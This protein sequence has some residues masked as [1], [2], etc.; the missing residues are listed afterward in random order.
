MKKISIVS[1]IIVVCTIVIGFEFLFVFGG[2]VLLLPNPAKP[3]IKSAE[4]NFT[5]RYEIDGETRILDDTLVCKF[6][7]FSIDEGR[8]KTRKWK[9][10][11]K[12]PQNNELFSYNF[13]NSKYYKP[14]YYEIVLQNIGQYKVL[15]ATASAEYFFQDPDYDA[16]PNMPCISVFD[17]NTG[18][19]MDDEQSKA[20]LDEHGFK[21][22]EW[23]CDP[24][25]E[26]TFK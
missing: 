23:Y 14:K 12:N 8:G 25:A 11:Y 5:L 6:D 10:Y 13:G 7:G 18:Y 4:F 22:I 2:G 9:K 21:I 3:A 26:N 24:P 1:G 17:T 16:D 19:Y 15:L 20:L